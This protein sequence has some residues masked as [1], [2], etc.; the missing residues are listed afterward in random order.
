M[1]D[2]N[3]IMPEN[4]YCPYCQ[5]GY[6]EYPDP[7]DDTTTIWHCLRDPEKGDNT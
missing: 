2:E 7:E 5:Y 3:C 1:N 4:P 6:I